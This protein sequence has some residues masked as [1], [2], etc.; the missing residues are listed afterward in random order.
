MTSV[1]E[2]DLTVEGDVKST[3]GTVEVKGKVLGNVEAA[4]VSLHQSGDIDGAI[5]AS[6]VSLQGD[7]KGTLKCDD[8]HVA[9]TSNVKGDVSAKTMTTERGAILI[10]KVNIAG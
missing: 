8:L 9:A 4:S 2:E 5:T 3:K 1:I 6:S 10:G 7:Y